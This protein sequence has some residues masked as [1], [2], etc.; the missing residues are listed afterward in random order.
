MISIGG[1]IWYEFEMK[2]KAKNVS[3]NFSKK[4]FISTYH[5]LFSKCCYEN[6]GHCVP[7]CYVNLVMTK[8]GHTLNLHSFVLS[9][10]VFLITARC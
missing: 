7:L 6:M 2:K 4:S 8:G 3:T 9:S 10:A 1:V 5:V